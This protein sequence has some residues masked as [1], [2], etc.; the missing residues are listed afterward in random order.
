MNVPSEKLV[1]TYSGSSHRIAFDLLL[2]PRGGPRD[3]LDDAP[4]DTSAPEAEGVGIVSAGEAG[5]LRQGR[6][7]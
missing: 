4:W 6:Q 2:R 5:C 1:A 7:L 3:D